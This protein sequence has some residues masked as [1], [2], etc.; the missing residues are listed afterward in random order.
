MCKPKVTCAKKLALLVVLLII[1][2]GS[3][4]AQISFKETAKHEQRKKR[5]LKQAS[6]AD[7]AYKDTHLNTEAYTFRKGKAARKRTVRDERD[8]YK[9]SE[10]GQAVQR[11]H[12]LK[13]RSRRQ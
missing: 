1:T 4:S 13:K 6:Q 3:A 5:F 7:A 9:F 10:N 2:I 12:K 11:K 8:K